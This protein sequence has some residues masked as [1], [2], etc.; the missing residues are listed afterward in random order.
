MPAGME[1]QRGGAHSFSVFLLLVFYLMP[2]T[3]Y[4]KNSAEKSKNV[5]CRG[6]ATAAQ[7]RVGKGL[8]LKVNSLITGTERNSGWP[9]GFCLEQLDENNAIYWHGENSGRSKL[10]GK[11]KSMFGYVIANLLCKYK[12]MQNLSFSPNL[13]PLARLFRSLIH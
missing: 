2:L 13:F 10:R 3:D 12:R 1:S 4:S 6:P 5:A 9:L 8:L 7:S 11:R